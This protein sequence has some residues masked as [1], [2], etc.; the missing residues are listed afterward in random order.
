MG[1]RGVLTRFGYERWC[2]DRTWAGEMVYGQDMG[3]RGGIL[4]EHDMSRK[5]GVLTGFGQE[6]V[7]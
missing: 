2:T 5:D 3:R 1:K 4:T 6:V 7:F